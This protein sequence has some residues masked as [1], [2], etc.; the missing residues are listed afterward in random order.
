[1]RSNSSL[2]MAM[3]GAYTDNAEAASLIASALF[4]E[5]VVWYFIRKYAIRLMAD[6]IEACAKEY[7]EEERAF[8]DEW[9]WEM[10]V[11]DRIEIDKTARV[12]SL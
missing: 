2:S 7:L 1:M 3:P 4:S 9:P 8:R 6:E 11:L 5:H 10:D 12:A